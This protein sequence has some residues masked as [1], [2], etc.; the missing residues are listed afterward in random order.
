MT[1]F[2]MLAIG[3]SNIIG[4]PTSGWIMDHFNGV[5]GLHGWQWL[6][7]FEGIPTVFVGVAAFFVLKNSPRD[8]H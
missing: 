3:V 4:N 6:F 7:L 2:F 1:A 8:A 5:S